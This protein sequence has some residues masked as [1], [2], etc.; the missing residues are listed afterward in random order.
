MLPLK[1][2]DI[3]LDPELTCHYWLVRKV[4][5]LVGYFGGLRTQ[6]LRSLEFGKVNSDG[7]ASFE[8]DQAGYWFVFE[9][10]KQRG[11]TEFSSFCVPRRQSDWI[12]PVASSDRTAVDYDPASVIDRYLSLLESD[13]N[14][15][16]NKLSGAFLKSAQGKK[17]KKFNNSP[18]GRNTLAK[19]AFEFAEELLL[20]NPQLFTGHCWRRSCGT[21]ASDAG[22]NV[23]T[24]MAQLGWTTPKTAIGYVRKSRM[25]SF[26]MSMFLSNVQR[27]NRDLDSVLAQVPSSKSG[28]RSVRKKKERVLSNI[29]SATTTVVDH[30]SD[31]S[32]KVL[33]HI[34]RLSKSDSRCKTAEMIATSSAKASLLADISAFPSVKQSSVQHSSDRH[35]S[36]QPSSVPVRPSPTQPSSVPELDSSQSG[37][38]H[39]HQVI[40]EIPAV[41]GVIVR[42]EPDSGSLARLDPRVAT[43]LG[44]LQNHGQIHVHFH[45]KS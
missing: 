30:N 35:S 3:V 24:L 39:I 34:S 29:P 9:R 32:D 18:M 14:L 4:A 41:S 37:D 16:R 8:V 13:L 20:P 25:T 5:C 44:N 2:E 28:L 26:Q 27:Q 11:M 17:G 38:A 21:N 23:T 33:K 42:G 1:I 10:A 36:I 22:C 31:L 40:D 6:E 15:P 7:D 19:V 43:I 45:F 12:A